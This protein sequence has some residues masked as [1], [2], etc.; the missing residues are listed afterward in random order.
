MRRQHY[1]ITV[2]EILDR[3]WLTWFDGLKVASE[4]TGQ[5][6]IVGSAAGQSAVRGLL[7]RIRDLGLLS[8]WVRRVGP[9]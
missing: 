6:T 1:E 2:E 5:T 8:L 4:T 7:A 3:R 9:H